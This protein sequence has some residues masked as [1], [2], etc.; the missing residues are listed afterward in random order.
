[1]KYQI[2]IFHFNVSLVPLLSETTTI[3]NA[4]KNRSIVDY[5]VTEIRQKR[6]ILKLSVPSSAQ[7]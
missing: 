7:L 4:T 6:T 2:Y 1:M 5:L 3:Q